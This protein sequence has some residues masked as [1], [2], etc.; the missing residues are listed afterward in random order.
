MTGPDKFKIDLEPAGK[1]AWNTQKG[2][3]LG[4]EYYAGLGLLHDRLDPFSKQEHLLFGVFD[5]AQR[6]DATDDSP[7][8]L[9]VGVGRALSSADG[10]KWLVKTIVGRVF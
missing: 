1:A 5:L 6:A 4:V 10:P 8:E 3:S 2:F 9:N 7:W